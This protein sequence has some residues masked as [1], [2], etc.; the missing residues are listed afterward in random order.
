MGD[1]LNSVSS[2]PSVVKTYPDIRSKSCDFGDS[3]H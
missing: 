3:F 2:A 1:L